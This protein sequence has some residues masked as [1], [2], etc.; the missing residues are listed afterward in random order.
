MEPITKNS[1]NQ[2][3]TSIWRDTDEILRRA[4]LGVREAVRDHAL[5]GNPVAAWRDN[6]VVML[7]PEQVLAELSRRRKPTPIATNDDGDD[8]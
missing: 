6:K 7:S 3:I 8:Q 2:P 1:E 4:R 5:A